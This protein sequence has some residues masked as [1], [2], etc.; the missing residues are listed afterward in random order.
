MIF[1]G[2]QCQLGSPGGAALLMTFQ[3]DPTREPPTIDLDYFLGTEKVPGRGIY[4]LEGDRLTICYRLNRGAVSPE[5]PTEFVT[6]PGRQEMMLI[7]QREK[8]DT[9]PVQDN[10]AK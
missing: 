4:R 6:H 2:D 5:R 1:A 3:L 8:A 7:L 10:P 9:R